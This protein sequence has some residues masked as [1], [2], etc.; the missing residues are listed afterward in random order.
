[1]PTLEA[2]LDFQIDAALRSLGDLDES[3]QKSASDFA[4]SLDLAIEL[5]VRTAESAG[6]TIPVEGDTTQLEQQIAD[7]LDQP[8]LIEVDADASGVFVQVQDALEQVD[9][10]LPISADTAEA[11]QQLDD[12][13]TVD[14]IVVSVEADT[15]DADDSIDN[16]A[17]SAQA[18]TESVSPLAEAT[19]KVGEAGTG[20]GAGT[21]VLT[22][23]LG[24]FSGKAFTAV[25]AAGGVAIGIHQLIDEGT[26]A[27]SAQQRYNTILGEFGD[28]LD[29]IKVGTLDKDIDKLGLAFGSTSADLQ[30]TSANLFQFART[31]N[32][33]GEASTEFTQRIIALAAR[34]VALNPALGSVSE[35]ADQLGARI[36]RGGK[37]V[38]AFSLSLT[39]QE[40]TSRALQDTHKKTTKELT[41]FDKAQ[42]AAAISA[43]RYGAVLG[44]DVS[45]GAKNA[46]NQNKALTAQIREIVETLGK[47]LVSPFFTALQAAI[48][49]ATAFGRVL[50][51]VVLRSLPAITIALEALAVPLELIADLLDA[52]PAPILEVVAA[53]FVFR[54]V[55]DLASRAM[56]RFGTNK[57]VDSALDATAAKVQNTGRVFTVFGKDVQTGALSV[58]QAAL[59]ATGALVAFQS[60]DEVSKGSAEGILSLA[61]A[62]GTMGA[63]LGPAGA[64]AGAAAGGI[65]GLAV[66]GLKAINVFGDLSDKLKEEDEAAKTVV[67]T[68]GDM[69]PSFDKLKAKVRELVT[70]EDAAANSSSKLVISLRAFRDVAEL[71]LGAAVRLHQQTA[72]GS[73]EFQAQSNIIAQLAAK[74]K[75]NADN[76][77]LAT[78]AIEAQ[79]PTLAETQQKYDDFVAA[80]TAGL[81]TTSQVFDTVQSELAQFGQSF[82]PEALNAQLD[83]QLNRITL[84]NQ[85]VAILVQRG[86]TDLAAQVAQQGPGKGLDLATAVLGATPDIQSQLNSKLGEVPKALANSKAQLEK[87]GPQFTQSGLGAGT[88]FAQGLSDGAVK[89]V[90]QAVAD[91]TSAVSAATPQ[92]AQSGDTAGQSFGTG[93]STGIATSAATSLPAAISAPVGVITGQVP[94]YQAAGQQLGNAAVVGLTLG[95]LIG[96]VTTLPTSLAQ[97][98]AIVLALTAPMLDAGTAVGAATGTGIG[99]GVAQ[100][101]PGALG[102]ATGALAGAQ[103]PFSAAGSQVGLAGGRALVEGLVDGSSRTEAVGELASRAWGVG[104]SRMP[105]ISARAVAAASNAIVGAAAGA[106]GS[107]F[108]AGF[109][110][111]QSLGAGVVSGL[112]SML[113]SVIAQASQLV[114]AAESA[115]RVA[116]KAKSPSQLFADIGRDL[117]AGMTLGITQTLGAQQTAGSSLVLAAAKGASKTPQVLVA[118]PAAGAQ[119]A[120]ATPVT[121]SEQMRRDAKRVGDG[122][123]IGQLVITP[124][125]DNP[126]TTALTTGRKLEATVFENGW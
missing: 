13:R 65:A 122:P 85:A 103:G 63:A 1:M 61:V 87:L 76:T 67:K 56:D 100:T 42:A 33:S 70:S 51:T 25:A 108:S 28:Q 78:Q 112:G 73:T 64:A 74:Q 45:E 106:A 102:A 68:T 79:G 116:A 93:L 27:T 105:D 22:S 110:V 80:L 98:P 44:K 32:A 58:N 77:F 26:A 24:A 123:L 29:R 2:E 8:A 83:E 72:I 7:A 53:F 126:V 101:L 23:S 66:A 15:A 47:P 117:G 31:A 125:N 119:A 118:A 96:I 12:L 114:F 94:A 17:E 55:V 21:N 60:V 10:T 104:L 57:A 36:Q 43:E 52:I 40:I 41:T 121:N 86:L 120:A 14:P 82:N 124:P 95:L 46:A 19:S 107:A 90:P 16:L 111:G 109:G 4:D 99:L 5:A 88:G 49:L 97:A 71:S 81:P 20:A 84:F 59:L 92:L 35:V 38:Q 48:P 50:S 115:A 9:L 91:V 89:G 30:N 37:S 62:G 3:L 69:G 113:G 11:Q 18:A 39:A 54:K 75:E 34:A 6:L